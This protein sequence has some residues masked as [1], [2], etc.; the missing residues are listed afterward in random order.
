MTHAAEGTLL[1]M[2]DG[3][4]AP[5]E[6]AQLQGH[7]AEC[8]SC[9]AELERLRR[10]SAT[11]DGAMAAL[12][13]P[14]PTL[15][16]Y[17]A[18]LRRRRAGWMAGTRRALARAAVLVLGVVGIASATL[19]GSP[20]RRWIEE[21]F[22]AGAAASPTPSA[23]APE[24]P[25]PPADP[26]P[27]AAAMAGVEILPL[28]GSV[29]VVLNDVHPGL[30]VRVRLADVEYVDVRGTGGAAGARFRT[31]PGRVSITDAGPGEIQIALPRQVR[32]ATIQVGE[33]AYMVKEGAQIR[34]LAPA[35][36][37]S[38]AE[39]VFPVGP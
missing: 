26:P 34:V 17:A 12:D 32:R 6:Q 4:L 20:V 15:P 33:R 3:R 10:L 25:A 24:Q 13:P 30:R 22:G 11:F 38:G 18:V 5:S 21:R 29:R 31:G 23:P 1:E 7:V 35:A 2:L 36:D 9:A 39:I 8:D 27:P 19:P 16:A 14:A 28:D 37:T